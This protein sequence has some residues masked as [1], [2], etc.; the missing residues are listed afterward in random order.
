MLFTN[1]ERSSDAL[2]PWQPSVGIQSLIRPF[3]TRKEKRHREGRCHAV[4]RG[5]TA[6]LGLGKV[7]GP[8]FGPGDLI[9][10]HLGQGVQ[11]PASLAL[12]CPPGGARSRAT[13][14]AWAGRARGQSVPG[15]VGVASG[16]SR[17][18][19]ERGPPWA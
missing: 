4:F 14:R 8:G 9:T 15:A 17:R 10:H 13:G 18:D 6:E 12:V 16:V 7:T 3:S 11:R 5:Y 1:K 2:G 19:H